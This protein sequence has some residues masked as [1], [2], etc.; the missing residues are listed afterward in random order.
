MNANARNHIG[1]TTVMFGN[2]I[3]QSSIYFNKNSWIQHG[4]SETGI[5]PTTVHIHPH[6]EK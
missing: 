4:I 5:S 1:N 6:R 3:V 2:K